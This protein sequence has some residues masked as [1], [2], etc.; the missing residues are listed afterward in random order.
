MV[1]AAVDIVQWY[2]VVCGVYCGYSNSRYREIVLYCVGSLLW[3]QQQ[4]IKGNIIVFCVEFIVVTVTIGI[5]QYNREY[6]VK[7]TDLSE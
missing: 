4:Q 1:T 2:C 7:Q 3:L 5:G 6:C